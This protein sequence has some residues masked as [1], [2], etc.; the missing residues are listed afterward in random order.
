MSI[1]AIEAALWVENCNRCEPPKSREEIR[2]IA[3][4][5]GQWESA[6]EAF[7][8]DDA[9]HAA[10]NWPDPL[11]PEA[12]HGIAGE[13]V[14][15]IEPHSEADPAALLIQ[16]LL[17]FGNVI[18]RSAHF[19][20]EADNH[21]MN[22]FAV[23]V[24]QTSKGRKGT[25]LGQIQKNLSP[26]DPNWSKDRVMG[27]M[28]SGEGLIWAARDPIRELKPYG[29]K[30]A[31][32][33]YKEIIA[34]A[35]VSDKRLLVVEPEF[36]RV[37][38]VAERESN[39]LSAIMRQAWDS[40]TLRILTKKQ[41]AV[42][43]GAHISIIGH[44]TKAELQ[45]LLTDIAIANGFANRVLWICARRSKLLPEGGVLHT[46]DFGPIQRQIKDAV[47]FARNV[48]ELRRDNEARAIWHEV[49][50]TLSEG[51]PG[52]FGSVT[53]RAEA[54][55]MRL[56]CLYALLDKSPVIG[57]EHLMAALAVWQYC[58]ASAR[59]IFGNAL[60]DPTA[61][62]IVRALRSRAEGMTRTE[63]RELFQRNKS[64]AEIGRA[65][66]VLLEYGLATVTHSRESEDQIRPTEQ[67]KAVTL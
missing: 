55:T 23:I 32:P 46:V 62:E 45:R 9:T 3:E 26:I 35:G 64:S 11:K 33:Q 16:F 4:S 58:E 29:K 34:D 61:D 24:G 20:A 22:L 59:S 53:S 49:Y 18:G 28:S 14:R 15:L 38:Q 50:P 54:Q 60:G 30:G 41:P 47:A 19:L 37:L 7:G 56:A 5:A 21:F 36:A 39:T 2:K 17:C 6:G 51:K 43:T 12:F 52:M 57:A 1:H 40:G 13:L 10:T 27:G 48:G 65:L 25:S 42:A 31:K 67:W 63:I 8:T 44:I 66:G